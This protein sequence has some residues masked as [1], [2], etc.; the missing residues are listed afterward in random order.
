VHSVS[1]VIM[2]YIIINKKVKAKHYINIK[3][4]V[5]EEKIERMRMLFLVNANDS[6]IGLKFQ[7]FE[8]INN[9]EKC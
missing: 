9:D 7:N 2:N 1:D 4:V 6:L 5:M 8:L 3:G